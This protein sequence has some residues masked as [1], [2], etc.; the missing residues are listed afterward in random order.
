MLR[1]IISVIIG[2]VIAVMCFMGFEMLNHQIHSNSM[3]DLSEQPILFW[4]ILLM[5]WIAGSSICGY[6]IRL[7]SQSDKKLLPR[8]ATGLLTLSAIANFT[9]ISHPIWVII[10]A[11]PSFYIFTMLGHKLSKS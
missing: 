3:T 10:L 5:G 11:L 2:L 9:M 6:L 4:I 1:N 7:I 8:I